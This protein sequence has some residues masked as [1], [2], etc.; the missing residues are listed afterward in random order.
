M[1][2][3]LSLVMVLVS[4]SALAGCASSERQ[5]RS[6]DSIASQ[7]PGQRVAEAPPEDWEMELKMP[8]R[9]DGRIT[10]DRELTGS[11]HAYSPTQHADE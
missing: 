1:F 10:K 4:L 7:I 6:A 3:P 8:A 9:S 5:V 11:L 2:R